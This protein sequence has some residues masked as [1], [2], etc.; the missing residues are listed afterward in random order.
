[1]ATGLSVQCVVVASVAAFAACG[2]SQRAAPPSS[3]A[4]PP[5]RDPAIEAE[6]QKACAGFPDDEQRSCPLIKWATGVEDTDGGVLIHLGA[7]APP[8]DRTARRA[9]CHRAWMAREGHSMRGPLSAVGIIS[10]DATAG[11]T[12]TDITL[13]SSDPASVADLRARTHRA[14]AWEHR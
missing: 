4:S 5:A 6:Y 1:M 11:T 8:P 14:F 13:V 10:I 9:R 3:Q 2:S 7:V 12:G